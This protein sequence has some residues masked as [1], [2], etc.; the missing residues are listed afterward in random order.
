MQT[1][2][3]ILVFIHILCAAV[4]V[5]YWIANIKKPTVVP[6]QFHAS[7]GAIVAGLAIVGITEM[8]DLGEVN[9]AKIAVKLIVGI[10]VAVAAFLGQR[11]VKKTGS[12]SAA[13]ANSVG[14]LA[15]LN[16]AVATIWR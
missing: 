15:I 10:A 2:V 16:I 11:S 14:I 8:A 13:L 3:G 6:G 4:I 7:L 9:N 12:V 5:G 1:V